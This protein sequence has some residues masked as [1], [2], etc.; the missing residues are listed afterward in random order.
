MSERGRTLVDK[1]AE[2]PGL[3]APAAT[4]TEAYLQ[5]A[6]RELHANV[7]GAQMSERDANKPEP[8]P[9]GAGTPVW[10][11]VIADMQERDRI[12]TAKYGTPLRVHNGRD[13]LLDAYQEALDLVVYLRQ[14]IE[15]RQ[16]ERCSRAGGSRGRCVLTRGHDGDHEWPTPPTATG[17]HCSICDVGTG[18]QHHSDCPNAFSNRTPTAECAPHLD[19][20]GAAASQHMNPE[21]GGETVAPLGGSPAPSSTRPK[22]APAAAVCGRCKGRK[23]AGK[24]EDCYML[25]ESG[26]KVGCCS[27]CAGTGS[28]P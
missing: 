6:L 15:E 3:W 19:G 25:E 2:D 18:Y 13:A 14:V 26:G 23:C 7:E 20:P 1:Q 16:Q 8:P 22:A 9:T 11:L 24:V 10:P 12:G 4:A 27:A 28:A 17:A 21:D 5:Q